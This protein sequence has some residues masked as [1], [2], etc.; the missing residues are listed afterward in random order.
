MRTIGVRGQDIF[1]ALAILLLFTTSILDRMWTVTLACALLVAGVIA[2]PEMRR[3][4][5]LVAVI[6]ALLS[7]V[8]AAALLR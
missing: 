3:S 4:A 8:F 5:V 2:F 1:T 7:A 6:A